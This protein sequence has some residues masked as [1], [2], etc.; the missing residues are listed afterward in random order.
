LLVHILSI[1]REYTRSRWIWVVK[2]HRTINIKF[3]IFRLFH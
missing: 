3:E 1:W 2:V